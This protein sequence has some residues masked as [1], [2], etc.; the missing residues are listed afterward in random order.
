MSFHFL[1]PFTISFVRISYCVTSILSSKIQNFQTKSFSFVE[2]HAI[3]Y[4]SIPILT[5]RYPGPADCGKLVVFFYNFIL[6]STPS[7]H[8]KFSGFSIMHNS[9]LW[10]N[11]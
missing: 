11:M 8:D 10:L 2:D 1:L 5:K 6:Y 9:L 3:I 4:S 7:S